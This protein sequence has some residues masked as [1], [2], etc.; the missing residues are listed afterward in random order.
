MVAN[1]SEF[2]AN[3]PV[4]GNLPR[5]YSPEGDPYAMVA[6]ETAGVFWV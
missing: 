5:D 3:N 2:V 4:K 1:I 6:D